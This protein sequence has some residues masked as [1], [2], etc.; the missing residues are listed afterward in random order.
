MFVFKAAAMVNL[1]FKFA[2]T[3]FTV[4]GDGRRSS[5]ETV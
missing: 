4:G 1:G 3:A 2:M 5:Y